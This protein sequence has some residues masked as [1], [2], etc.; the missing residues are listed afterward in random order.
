[1]IDSSKKMTKEVVDEIKLLVGAQ[2]FD[3]VI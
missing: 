1:M 2:K 3:C